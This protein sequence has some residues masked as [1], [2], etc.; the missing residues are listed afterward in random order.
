MI[1]DCLKFTFFKKSGQPIQ[2]NQYGVWHALV[3]EKLLC[4]PA[5]TFLYAHLP[6]SHKYPRG[7][8]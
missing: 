8:L 3:G 2:G 7:V 4:P 5:P 6:A 1:Y